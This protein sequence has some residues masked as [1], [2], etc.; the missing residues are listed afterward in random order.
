MLIYFYPKERYR[1]WWW[2]YSIQQDESDSGENEVEI[3]ESIGD[4]G[5]NVQQLTNAEKVD[6]V[7]DGIQL[8]DNSGG[9]SATYAQGIGFT[10]NSVR[11]AVYASHESTQQAHV[12]FN[13]FWINICVLVLASVAHAFGLEGWECALTV[14]PLGSR[15]Q[16]TPCWTHRLQPPINSV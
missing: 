11:I 2:G 9:E 5:G 4:T 12:L 3:N 14:Y 13:N 10:E 1:W 7:I 16:L 6:M 15:S 8:N